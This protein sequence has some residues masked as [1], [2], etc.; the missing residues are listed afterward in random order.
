M[1]NNFLNIERKI[2]ALTIIQIC[3][4]DKKNILGHSRS[5]KNGHTKTHIEESLSIKYLKKKKNYAVKL[6]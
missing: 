4:G 1:T 5:Q 6:F 2:I 3:E